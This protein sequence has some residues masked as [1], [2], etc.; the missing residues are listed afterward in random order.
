MT[1]TNIVLNKRDQIQKIIY[2]IIP[3]VRNSRKSETI[4]IGSRLVVVRVQD[5]EKEN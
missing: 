5:V 1:L 3:L 2:C 4:V